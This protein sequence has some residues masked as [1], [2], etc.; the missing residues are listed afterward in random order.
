MS[1][2]VFDDGKRLS[3]ATILLEFEDGSTLEANITGLSSTVT[4][5]SMEPIFDPSPYVD[6][7][8]EQLGPVASNI[9]FK[10]ERVDF[11][12]TYTDPSLTPRDQSVD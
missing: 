7:R 2:Q 5:V 12:G 4:T 10:F 8:T 3:R 9:G 6:F 11:S 1:K